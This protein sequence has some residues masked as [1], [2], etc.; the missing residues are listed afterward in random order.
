MFDLGFIVG[1]WYG[2]FGMLSGLALHALGFF[3]PHTTRQSFTGGPAW[4]LQETEAGGPSEPLNHIE[5]DLYE[6]NTNVGLLQKEGREAIDGF[7]RMWFWSVSVTG[8]GTCQPSNR[9]RSVQSPHSNLPPLPSSL[10]FS[11]PPSFLGPHISGRCRKKKKKKKN[12][13]EPRRTR[14]PPVPRPVF[15]TA[16][17]EPFFR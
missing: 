11:L 1:K 5:S 6:N 12:Q 7:V 2:F 10:P 16:T 3:S 17:A 13:E 9:S 8:R 4:K 15:A 14:V